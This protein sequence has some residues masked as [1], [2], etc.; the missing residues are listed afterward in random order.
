MSIK[1]DDLSNIDA[2]EEWF[3]RGFNHI[4]EKI[5][6]SLPMK[7]L[8]SCQR[9]N[10]AWKSMVTSCIE[11]KHSTSVKI[12]NN[13]INEVWRSRKPCSLTLAKYEKAERSLFHLWDIVSDEKNVIFVVWDRNSYRTDGHRIVVLDAKTLEQTQC[14]HLR[15]L[16]DLMADEE[17]TIVRLAM[18]EKYLVA[19]VFLENSYTGII[20]N[21]VDQDFYINPL[22]LK[23]GLGVITHQLIEIGSIGDFVL[24]LENYFRYNYRRLSTLNK[25]MCLPL[26]F[27]ERAGAWE[28]AFTKWDLTNGS[29]VEFKRHNLTEAKKVEFLYHPEPEKC[30]SLTMAKGKIELHNLLNPTDKPIWQQ[31]KQYFYEPSLEYL[32]SNFA[33][34]R[35]GSDLLEIYR[36]ADGHLEQSIELSTF[37]Q[38]E[39]VQIRSQ[40]VAVLGLVK[41]DPE[42]CDVSRDLIVFDLKTGQKILSVL[43]EKI[44]PLEE[45]IYYAM[46]L[47]FVLEKDRLL[48]LQINGNI[49]GAK[50]WIQ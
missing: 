46:H 39:K 41:R 15:D 1:N 28:V 25:I 23:R 17:Q 37:K 33:A 43:E 38:I 4:L 36:T 13:L 42:T 18:S 16:L 40:R 3:E 10:K 8:L 30:L 7:S 6:L 27:Q 29:F 5:F 47:T 21:R 48:L 50:F 26:I 22:R 12:Q 14:F 31:S 20:W 35:W 49:Q 2:L 32:D 24:V 34:V 45:N 44:L 19:N 9:V 11:S